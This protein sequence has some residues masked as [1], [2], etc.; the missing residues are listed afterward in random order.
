MNDPLYAEILDLL[1]ESSAGLTIRQ[2][3]RAVAATS[4]NQLIAA[5]VDLEE[6]GQIDMG[7]DGRYTRRARPPKRFDQRSRSSYLDQRTRRGGVMTAEGHIPYFQHP[8]GWSLPVVIDNNGRPKRKNRRLVYALPGG[9]EFQPEDEQ[10]IARKL[11]G[12][13]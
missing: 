3:M 7:P 6:G 10:S 12:R 2:M 13:E 5:L 11:E 1:D 4:E 9:G 8:S